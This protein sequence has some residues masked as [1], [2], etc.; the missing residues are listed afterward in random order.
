MGERLLV[1]NLGLLDAIE[2]HICGE[3]DATMG[4]LT[5]TLARQYEGKDIAIK[6]DN[7][8]GINTEGNPDKL[9][10]V[11]WVNMSDTY[12]DHLAHLLDKKRLEMR[13]TASLVYMIDGS[14]VLSLPVLKRKPPKQG[15]KEP[16]WLPVVLVPGPAMSTEEQQRQRE[17]YWKWSEPISSAD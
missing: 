11:F 8:W 13:P 16:R 10:V 6:G 5:E 17:K 12:I 4:V 14:G 1:L 9:A 7:W 15:F 3:G 2:Q